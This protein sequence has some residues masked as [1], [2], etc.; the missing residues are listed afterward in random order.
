MNVH[1]RQLELHR[2]HPGLT[3]PIASSYAEAASV[4][5]ARHH[6]PPVEC[7]VWDADGERAVSL[8]WDVPDPR[9]WAAWANEIDATEAGAVGLVLGMLESCTG[10][11]AV[12]RAETRTGAD[13][14]V[15]PADAGYDDLEH[16]WRLEISGVDRGSASVIR[17]RVT[18]KIW[19][20]R[21][22]S[23]NLPA[24]VGVVGF[25]VR[26]IIVEPVEDE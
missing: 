18:E 16:C 22:G 19:Q 9:T 3:E 17:R 6:I 20:T 8:E 26:M 25:E 13:Y 15:G 14:Y 11:V 7:A 1:L 24:L 21:R 5:L 23:S 2:R 10:H 12:R 4:C